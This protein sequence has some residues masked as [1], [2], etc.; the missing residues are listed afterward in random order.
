MY[1][2]K[3]CA[4]LMMLMPIGLSIMAILHGPKAPLS[5]AAR[6]L[7]EHG[8]TLAV[9]AVFFAVGMGA[10]TTFKNN[11]PNVVPF[12]ADVWIAQTERWFLGKSPWRYA[13]EIKGQTW[14]TFIVSS[15]IFIWSLQWFG[16][17]FFVALW[18]NRMAKIRYFWALALTICIVGTVMATLLSSA[19]PI[20]YPDLFGGPRFVELRSTLQG[21]APTVAIRTT[22]DYLLDA[23]QSGSVDFG[24]GI[25]AMPS[26]HVAMVVLNAHLLWSVHRV[27]GFF[28]WLFA[29]TIYYASIYT[30]WHY[31]L[32]GIVSFAVVTAIW[33]FTGRMIG[34][35]PSSPTAPG[36][37]FPLA[38][39]GGQA[40]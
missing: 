6:V 3:L 39:G 36:R 34:L 7:R 13:H 27:V 23:Y 40:A 24:T 11:I 31:A 19:G 5:Y 16:T 4:A 9:V 14:S 2:T 10:Y 18:S 17:V 15:Y 22:A 29:A 32:D 35:L 37:G 20:F 28:G 33:W 12:Y 25:S 26:V 8:L 21:I 38:Q 30:G 1:L